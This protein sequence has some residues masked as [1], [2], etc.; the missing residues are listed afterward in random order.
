MLALRVTL[1]K[2]DGKW[3][4]FDVTPIS[5]ESNEDRGNS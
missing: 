3:L 2:K 4:V 5:A 1:S